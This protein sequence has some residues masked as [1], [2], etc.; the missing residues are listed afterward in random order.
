MPIRPVDEADLPLIL[1]W[2]NAPEVRR[3]SFSR[4]VITEIEHRAWFERTRTDS[5]LR[6]YVFLSDEG[7]RCGVVT[8]IDLNPRD[9]TAT[10]G[11]YSAPDAPEGNGT[12]LGICALDEAF[13][14][15]GLHKV[16]AEV[17]VTNARSVHFHEKLGFVREGLLR[18]N[19]FNGLEV[20][21]VLRFGLL[22][23]EWVERRPALV[24]ASATARPR[25][26]MSND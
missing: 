25:S 9:R 8:F 10:W 16:N 4:H 17:L 22:W 5:R 1:A 15:L 20:T 26:S 24:S 18:E 23:P 13:G 21:D 2:R 3:N 12:R 14:P 11:F 19:Y 7:L 6:A